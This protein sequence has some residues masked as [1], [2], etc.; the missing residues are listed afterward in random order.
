MNDEILK[1]CEQTNLDLHWTQND[2]GYAVD[3]EYL[4]N[5]QSLLGKDD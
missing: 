1:L 2:K 4:A 5:G 3:I